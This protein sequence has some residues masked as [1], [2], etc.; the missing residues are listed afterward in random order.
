MAEA[1]DALLAARL[2]RAI[3]QALNPKPPY[4]PLSD[5]ERRRLMRM[6]KP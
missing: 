6:L 3:H 2:E 5:I 1:R 4:E